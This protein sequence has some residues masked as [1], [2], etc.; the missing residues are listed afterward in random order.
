MTKFLHLGMSLGDVILKTTAAPAKA[1]GRSGDLGTLAPGAV[2]DLFVF[3]IEEG[4]FPLED[5][6]LV[7]QIARRRIKPERVMKGGKWIDPA[8][9]RGSLRP[10]ESCDYEVLRDLEESA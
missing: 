9:C 6:H 1:I 5:T 10:L 3:S 7:R 2:A 4:E 8:A